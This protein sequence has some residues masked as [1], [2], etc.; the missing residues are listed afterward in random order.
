MLTAVCFFLS[1]VTSSERSVKL[2][3]LKNTLFF[4]NIWLLFKKF[5]LSAVTEIFS[6]GLFI[7]KLGFTISNFGSIDKKSSSATLCLVF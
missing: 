7:V 4:R 1:N 3:D 6:F 5:P 2:L